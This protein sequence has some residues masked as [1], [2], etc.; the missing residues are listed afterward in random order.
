MRP[1]LDKIRLLER[2]GVLR[3]ARMSATKE[4][5]TGT[6]RGR[7]GRQETGARKSR[8]CGP[9]YVLCGLSWTS[10]HRLVKVVQTNRYVPLPPKTR[11]RLTTTPPCLHV[12]SDPGRC[13]LPAWGVDGQK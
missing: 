13:A 10:P 7:R 2:T 9:R 11:V 3:R 1:M 8:R 5:A 6:V 4:T 12:A